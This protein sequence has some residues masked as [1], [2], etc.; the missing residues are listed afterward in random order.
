MA[1][2]LQREVNNGGYHQFFSNSS[3]KHAL[4]VVPALQSIDCD[5]PAALTQ[6]AI[7]ALN[8]R[9]LNLKAIEDSIFK[10]DAERDQALD[11]LEQQFYK[12][13]K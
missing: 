10:P 3:R 2:A 13:S 6:K 8:L 12:I 9:P 4:D 11:A 1:L 7:E 5:A